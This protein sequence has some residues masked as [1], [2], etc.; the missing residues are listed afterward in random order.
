M[1]V[2][3]GHL[4]CERRLRLSEGVRQCE[5]RIIE[6]E[7]RIE[8]HQRLWS[9]IAADRCQ[10]RAHIQLERNL[11]QGLISLHVHRAILL[12]ELNDAK[13][14]RKVS[15]LA[16]R[17]ADELSPTDSVRYDRLARTIAWLDGLP[18]TT[19]LCDVIA[20]QRE[21]ALRELF[22][23]EKQQLLRTGRPFLHH[24]AADIH[25]SNASPLG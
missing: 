6:A 23:I 17:P 14:P 4:C 10:R 7:R 20:D 5:M 21:R 15:A 8:S 11:L 1:M 16:Q 9:I 18:H 12:H 3:G 22:Q 2:V 19:L 13:V 24:G 25:A